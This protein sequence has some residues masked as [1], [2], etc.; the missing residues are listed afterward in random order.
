MKTL[1]PFLLTLAGLGLAQETK[2][3]PEKPTAA[4]ITVEDNN[5]KA[6]WELSPDDIHVLNI[7]AQKGEGTFH[8]RLIAYWRQQRIELASRPDF[9]PPSLK[10]D[11]DAI[12]AEEAK[13][14]AKIEASVGAVTKVVK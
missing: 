8:D 14:R 2:P 12:K 7:L 6:I 11:D 4:K 3:V 1:L 9:A 10:A 5:G 13:K